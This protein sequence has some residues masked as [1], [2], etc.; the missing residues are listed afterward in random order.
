MRTAPIDRRDFLS[1]L[2]SAV[3]DPERPLWLPGRKLISIPKPI[4]QTL[5]WTWHSDPFYVPMFGG[6][7][8]G[9]YRFDYAN[10]KLEITGVPWKRW[11][12]ESRRARLRRNVPFPE[13]S[14]EGTTRRCA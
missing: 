7:V 1:L 9:P 5:H 11:R 4:R 14:F 2:A 10:G 13:S 8:S 3:L 12:V 6:A